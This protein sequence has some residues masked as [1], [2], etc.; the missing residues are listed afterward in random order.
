VL[1]RFKP[2]ERP[3]IEDAVRRAAQAVLVWL[4]EGVAACMNR[5]NADPEAKK[6]AKK[7]ETKPGEQDPPVAT[8]GR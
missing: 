1:G 4:H 6:P 3:V 5:F 8:G 2:G 7:P